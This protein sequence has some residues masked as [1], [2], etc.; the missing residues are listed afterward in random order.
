VEHVRT[1]FLRRVAHDIASPT[2]VTMTVLDELAAAQN[3]R[4]ELV[5]MAKRS[6]RR[7]MRLSEHLALVAELES[8]VLAPELARIDLSTLVTQALSDAVA[9]DGRRDIGA[10]AEVPPQP[11][12]V[13]ADAKLLLLVLREV[14]GNA[15][16]L[17]RSRVEIALVSDGALATVS[18]QDD[19]PGFAAESAT[20]LGHRFVS[21]ASARGLG[22]SLSMGIEILHSHG[23]TLSVDA[24][25]LPPGRGTAPGARVVMTLPILA[26]Q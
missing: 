15:L 2:G 26:D 9:I 13:G 16:K 23:G 24:S 12:P 18:V 11:V 10:T 4:P 20:T 7:L 17:A 6:L 25:T 14:I 3:P 22:L 1:E 5:A 8:G 19:G 21:R